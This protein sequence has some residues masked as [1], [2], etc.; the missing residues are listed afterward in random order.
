M[1]V[2]QL[3]ILLILLLMKL[4][5][6]IYIFFIIST[7]ISSCATMVQPSGGPVDTTPP[8]PESFDP[9]NGSM[10][11]KKKKIIIRF[12]EFI[13][14]DK[15]TQQMVVS[16]Q[17]P[18]E[19]KVNINGKKLIIDLPDSLR[20]NTTYTIFF[21]DAVV[22]FRENLPVHNFSYVFSTGDIV[23]SLNIKGQAVNAFNHTNYEELFVMLYKQSTDS[24]IYNHKP[25]YLC[26]AEKDGHFFLNNLAAG[27]YQIYA[28]K[29]ENR[30]YMYNQ[31][32]EEIAFL[33]S[34]VVPFYEY[35]AIDP[36]MDSIT[37]KKDIAKPADINMFVFSET[38]DETKLMSNRTYPPN[39][40]VFIFNRAV[41]DFQMEALDFKTDTI[42]H[43]EVYG[44]NRD[45]ITT[46]LMAIDKDTI[47]IALSDGND[48]LDT[49]ELVLVKKKSRA[50][51]RN[52]RNKKN[53][54]IDKPK[55]KPIPKISFTTNIKGEFP[56]FGIIT[57]KF[58]V[59][60]NSYEFSRFELY[61]A[62]DTLWIPIKHSEY[63]S[64]SINR[65]SINIKAKFDERE[66]YKLLI[67]DSSFYDIYYATNDT[68]QKEFF[69]TE[70][71]QY[72][73]LKLDINYNNEDRLI[74]Q[75]LN[76]KEAVLQEN[77][78][79]SSQVIFYPYLKDGKYKI[80]AIWDKNHNG[81]WDTGDLDK[82]I[83]PEQIYYVP[84]TI[85]IRANW[86]TEQIWEIK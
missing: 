29:D 86:D 82:K 20:E 59:P 48:K 2:F 34:L 81:K 35:P 21:G 65:L 44:Q 73:S 38:P 63:M 79:D 84:K 62:K 66:K 51:V 55:P 85:D 26:K 8:V 47:H 31:P 25:Y 78:I 3:I 27:K 10:N 61:K 6:R 53:I 16:P 41:A 43:R 13:V 39:K 58:K 83:Q 32:N 69:T 75:L 64:D 37:N 36:K 9:P 70:M 22:N 4:H 60:L 54:E 14:L 17:M 11:V 76:N 28:L 80:K 1:F 68:F 57:L 77:I 33:D 42:W 46:Y 18:E 74:I 19:P 49:L 5:I 7:I 56:F 67:R 23:D 12:D 72:G 50:I 24:A 15:L 52:R 30:D 45:S 40:A 71:R